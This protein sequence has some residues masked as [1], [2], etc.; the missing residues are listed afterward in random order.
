MKK[1]KIEKK[2]ISF[3]VLIKYIVLFVISLVLMAVGFM[4]VIP[5]LNFGLDLKG[6]FEILYKVSS[7]DGS[8]VTSD[9]VTNTYKTITKRIDNLGVSEPNISIEGTDRIRVQLAGVKDPDTA[10][11]TLGQV[12][13]LTFRDTK[14]NLVMNSDVLDAGK[15]QYQY[16]DLKHQVVLKIKDIDT[17]YKQTEKIRKSD[18]PI[19]VIWL[20]FEYMKDSYE[21]DKDSCGDSSSH[22]LSAATIQTELTGQYVTISGNFTE[23]EAKML[24]DQINSGS[25]PTKLTEISSKNVSAAFGENSLNKTFIAGVVGLSIVILFMIIKYRTAGLVA[26]FGLI[27]YTLITLSTYWLVGGVLTLP[28]IAAMLLG[29]GMAV[30][31]NIINFSRIKDELKKSASL[32]QANKVGNKNSLGTIIDANITTLIVAIILFIFGQS[33]IK[34]FATMLMISIFVTLVVM[35]FLCRIILNKLVQTEYFDNKLNAL[36]GY[37]KCENK[38]EVKFDFMKNKKPFIFATIIM[39]V[40][41]VLS[42]V[43]NGFNLSVEFKGGTSIALKSED[44]IDQ[45]DVKQSIEKMGYKI[46]DIT[47]IDEYE[48]NVNIENSLTED[49]LIQTQNTLTEEY[50]AS[51]DLNVVSNVV[52]KELIKNAIKSLLFAIIGVVIYVSIRLSFNYAI[53]AIVALVHDVL[54]TCIVFSIFKL[55]VS[56]IFIAAILSIIGYSINDTIVTFDRIRENEK[57]AKKIKDKKDLANIINKSIHETLSRNIWT[58]VTTLIPVV[59]LITLGAHEVFNFNIAMLVGLIAGSYSSLFIASY[60]YYA[61]E[62]RTVGKEKKKKWYEEDEVSELK[63]KGI[64]D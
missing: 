21:K 42:L 43:F 51:T 12:A 27:L 31:S 20:D 25:L 35:V 30:D 52:K 7:V 37:K 10:R 56:T 57:K 53:S 61:L 48:V 4:K 29:I 24:T 34:G 14:D 9:M 18:T 8:E 44:K 62:K 49:E 47:S 26:S 1:N 63:V 15:A 5:S 11:K 58:S 60:V 50:N 59:C 28:G 6:G 19:M 36:I 22:C 17:F 64:N 55:E 39:V 2:N 23:E 13:N 40:A 16:E 45:N 46:T 32:N 38:K 33:S 54:I 3:K 41:G